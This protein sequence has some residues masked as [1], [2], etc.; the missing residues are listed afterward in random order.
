MRALGASRT[1]VATG[2]VLA[3]NWARNPLWTRARAV[4]SLDLNFAGTK[5]LDSRVTFTRASSGTYVGSD[6]VLQTA[7]TDEARFDHNPTTGESLGLLVEEPRTNS[8]VR[9]EEFGTTWTATG[10]SSITADAATAPNGAATADTLVETTGVSEV[11]R[12]L[13]N[14][15]ITSGSSYTVSAFAKQAQRRYCYLLFTPNNTWNGTS[16]IA[17]FDLQTGTIVNVANCTATITAFPDGWYRL[18][19][20]TT[21]TAT[22]AAALICIGSSSTGSVQ[23][24]IGDG[25]NAITVWG[26]QFETGSFATSYISTTSATV[27]RAADVASITGSNFSSWYNQTEGTVFSD[28]NIIASQVQN[29]TVWQLGG[30][31]IL[32]SLRQPQGTSNQ[33]RALI[34]GTFTASPGTG[35]LLSAGTS[36]A[37]V[38][39][40]GTAG[41]LQVASSGVD[42]TGSSL[43]AN[44]LDIGSLNPGSSLNG[45]IKRLTYWPVRLANTTIQ[46]I[47][48]P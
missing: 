1:S 30:G 6:G 40:L 46:S 8:F 48:T 33:F 41:R 47:T 15:S 38:A 16:T 4:P 3:G 36:K 44:K 18:T 29:Q 34:G 23:T 19:A 12:V 10:L 43:D 35:G 21:A 27:T 42:S 17:Y 24:Y 37:G 14:T 28:S 11:H 45:T 9:S 13:Q 7:A 32:S 39:Y 5:T 25:S 22:N 20:T 31:T 2:G 26:A